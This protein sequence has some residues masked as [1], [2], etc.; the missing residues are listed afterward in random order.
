MPP[1][2]AQPDIVQSD[3]RKIVV[4]NSEIYNRKRKITQVRLNYSDQTIHFLYFFVKSHCCGGGNFAVFCLGPSDV[5][6]ELFYIFS[7]KS[8]FSRC[9]TYS[10]KSTSPGSL[11]KSWFFCLPRDSQFW[12]QACLSARQKS[13]FLYTQDARTC[14]FKVDPHK[15]PQG[16][17]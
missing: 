6:P 16:G 5:V 14:F 8:R 17:N 15:S 7:R 11:A 12:C 2:G 4:G 3:Y 1:L 9:F 13:R 10:L